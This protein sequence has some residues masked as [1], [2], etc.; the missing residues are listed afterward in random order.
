VQHLKDDASVETDGALTSAI[1]KSDQL[2]GLQ[3]SLA[4]VAEKLAKDG[5]GLSLDMLAQDCAEIDI[6]QTAALENS[7]AAEADELQQRLSDTAEQRSQARDAFQAVG[8]DDAAAK[9]AADKQEALA[10]MKEVAERYVRVRTSVLL[11]Q[12]SIDRYRREK[13]APLL[14]RAGEL[15]ATLSG[16]SFVGLSVVFDDQDNAQLTG[17]RP[18]GQKV[19]AS[20]MST[21]SA[22]QLYLA[23]RVASVEDYQ[24]RA[25]TLPFV[26]DDLFINFDDNRAAA[27]FQVLTELAQKTQ[28]LFFTHHQH[29]VNIARDALG[30]SVHVVNLQTDGAMDTPSR[31]PDKAKA[32]F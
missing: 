11:L 22:D 15:F 23:L 28:V 3:A 2:R 24:T 29:L 5:D 10:E 4:D 8:G 9:A 16:G 6:D 12:W 1:E 20:G 31:P 32:A 7:I 14:K 27:G 25:N 26:T 21:G 19:S 13:Q 30:A 17:V 18:S